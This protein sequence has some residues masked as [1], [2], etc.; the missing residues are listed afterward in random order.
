MVLLE[1]D[2][3]NVGGIGVDNHIA[4]VILWVFGDHSNVA[5]GDVQLDEAT[6]IDVTRVLEIDCLT[7]QCEVNRPTGEA[8]VCI[9]GDKLSPFRVL[10]VANQKFCAAVRQCRDC[11][12]Y[13]EMCIRDPIHD[14]TWVLGDKRE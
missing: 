11:T 1:R 13:L 14:V 2:C 4:Y 12:A 9:P 5:H 6:S 7:I 8:I 3:L 10:V